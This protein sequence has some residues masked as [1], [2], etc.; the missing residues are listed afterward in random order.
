VTDADIAELVA[1]AGADNA[2][3]KAAMATKNTAF[4]ETAAQEMADKGITGTPTVFVNGRE[5]TGM[6]V[7]QL[8]DAIEKAVSAG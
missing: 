1:K 5:L 3:V 6:S 8:R 4:F 7:P 2:Q